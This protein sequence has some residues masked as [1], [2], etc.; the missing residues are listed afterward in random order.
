[1]KNDSF[2][3]W[4]SQIDVDRPHMKVEEIK[5]NTEMKY[6][7]FED[8]ILGYEEFKEGETHNKSSSI[9]FYKHNPEDPISISSL[10]P[11]REEGPALLF[12]NGSSFYFLDGK[13]KDKE[14][15]EKDP[16]VSVYLRKQ[17]VINKINKL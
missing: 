16:K 14:S 6:Y 4:L 9:C 3:Y 13:R 8:K 2:E 10:L 5:Y 15:W 11:H 17:N 7:I 12:K 1:M